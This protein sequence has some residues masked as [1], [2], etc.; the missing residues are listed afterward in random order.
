MNSE[1]I[2]VSND[3]FE[4]IQ[5]QLEIYGGDQRQTRN[6]VMV[7]CPFHDED[8]PS[9][10]INLDSE[11]NIPLGYFHCLAAETG[12]VTNKGIRQ[13]HKL[14]D[15]RTKVMDGNGHWIT[16]VFKCYGIQQLYKIC[17]V[18]NQQR[19]TIYAT[20]KHRWFV[21][22]KTKTTLQ[23]KEGNLLKCQLT[24]FPWKVERVS[25][26]DRTEPVYCCTVPTTGSFLL[27]GGIV[28]G[29]CLGC[30]KKGVWNTFAK[31]TNLEP[32]ADW[33]FKVGSHISSVSRDTEQAL[34]GTTRYTID[35]LFASLGQ[36]AA[37]KWPVYENWRD[38]SGKFLNKL[39][40]YMIIQDY[41][42]ILFPVQVNG[43]IVGGIRGTLTKTKV[44]YLTSTGSW[45]KK[46]G[47]FPYDYTKA[48]LRKTQQGFVVVVE[49][50]RDALRLLT[51]GI[52]AVS[53]L[54]S[55]NFS[56]PKAL[57]LA[58]LPSITK[59]Y[60][61]GD[62]DRAGREMNALVKR[63]CT[64][65]KVTTISY[66]DLPEGCDPAKL[67]SDALEDIREQLCEKVEYA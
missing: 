60:T 63:T 39:G 67:P 17:L 25:F 37:I 64:L 7:I 47:L 16:V 55:A 22:D 12:V 54:G 66:G 62:N 32:I 38:F 28:T 6:S 26:T 10:G 59:I 46:Y 18:R 51:V 43:K 40:A 52:P 42:M 8:T 35:G 45:V 61:F 48:L 4:T 27:E 56:T 49:G 20:A 1:N 44:S 19:K 33:Q 2:S 13:I 15:K 31:K 41:S 50:P 57:L 23:L 3:A 21:G 14:V 65:T 5:R 36:P 34:L 9:C 30:R 24:K 11:S 29:N 53:I 58:N